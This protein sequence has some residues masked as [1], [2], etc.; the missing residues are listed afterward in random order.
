MSNQPTSIAIDTED[1]NIAKG[2]HTIQKK[3]SQ[4]PNAPKLKSSPKPKHGDN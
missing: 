2:R 3:H 1:K 4:T